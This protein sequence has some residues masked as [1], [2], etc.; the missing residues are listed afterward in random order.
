MALKKGDVVVPI[1]TLKEVVDFL[2]KAD[3]ETLRLLRSF[4]SAG[5]PVEDAKLLTS[6]RKVSKVYKD[7]LEVS[8]SK[9]YVWEENLDYFVR[10]PDEIEGSRRPRNTSKA[11]NVQGSES[12][13]STDSGTAQPSAVQ[14]SSQ[15]SEESV[16][17]SVE[18]PS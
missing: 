5:A 18:R 17:E 2:A 10:A 7:T 1:G 14:D 13:S 4:L 9:E 3:A 16:P 11:K 12:L 8:L 15:R 6:P